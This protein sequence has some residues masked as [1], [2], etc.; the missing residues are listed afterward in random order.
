MR[1]L[2]LA[3][4][5]ALAVATPAYA[6]NFQQ[7]MENALENNRL[8]MQMQDNLNRALQQQ[9][10]PYNPNAWNGYSTYNAPRNCY[11]GTLYC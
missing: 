1:N 4:A 8:N 3:T 5:V 6:Q 10:T 2:L 9:V 7:Q 11:G